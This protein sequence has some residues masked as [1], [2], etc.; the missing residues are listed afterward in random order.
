MIRIE[1]YGH[2]VYHEDSDHDGYDYLAHKIQAEEAKVLFEYARV[3]GS[4]EFET[5][6][7]KNYTL[8]HNNSAG[9]YSIV[10]R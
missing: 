4:A 8:T 2:P 6:L 7:S 5:H 3:H 10:K 9:T 1:L